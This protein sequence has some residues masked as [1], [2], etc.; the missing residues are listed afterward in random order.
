MYI[1]GNQNVLDHQFKKQQQTIALKMAS[2]S[3]FSRLESFKPTLKFSDLQLNCPYLI[4]GARRLATKYGTQILC[5][6]L[7]NDEDG[8][9][10]LPGR[11]S[12]MS[13]KLL[14]DL[15]GGQMNLVVVEQVG[16]TWRLRL[17][18]S[19]ETDLPITQF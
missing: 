10:F 5:Q 13:D 17:E 19:S 15:N 1:N 11:F 8:E 3:E 12:K 7:V 14:E 6:L 18:C 2:I 16:R 4:T 9:I